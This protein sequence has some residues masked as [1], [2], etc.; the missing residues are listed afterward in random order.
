MK[1]LFIVFLLPLLAFT[2]NQSPRQLNGAYQPAGSGTDITLLFDGYWVQFG[3]RA[4]TGRVRA[5][6]S[7]QRK[8]GTISKPS[9]AF[10]SGSELRVFD[11][12]LK[13]GKLWRVW[14]GAAPE[15]NRTRSISGG[16]RGWPGCGTAIWKAYGNWPDPG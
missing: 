5:A 11:Y 2:G 8:A 14:P 4:G 12:S 10:G 9:I 3:T 1:I 15:V 13:G 16:F 7:T 6:P